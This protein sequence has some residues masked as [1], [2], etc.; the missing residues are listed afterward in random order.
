MK[1]IVYRNSFVGFAT[2]LSL[3][4]L[5]SSAFIYS[6][7]AAAITNST[8]NETSK[9]FRAVTTEVFRFMAGNNTALATREETMK[10]IISGSVSSIPNFPKIRPSDPVTVV[11][12]IMNKITKT[13]QNVEGLEFINVVTGL[14]LRNAINFNFTSQLISNIVVERE[15]ACQ[16]QISNALS[17]NS[18][19]VI[20]AFNIT[21]SK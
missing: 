13:E 8:N 17:D 1:S 16:D 6:V 21:I 5:C 20:C 19:R 7:A 9:N 10:D 12:K 4:L 11:G 18:S 14:E 15:S 3:F 2:S